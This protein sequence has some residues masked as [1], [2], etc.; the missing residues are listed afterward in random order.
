[1]DSKLYEELCRQFVARE[2]GVPLESVTSPKIPNPQRPDMP[3]YAH[4][5]DLYWEV[6]N[7]VALYLHIA[8]A[9]WRGSDNVK[10]GEVLLLQKVREKVAAH[11]AL[12]ITSHGFDPG[13]IAAAMDDGIGLHVVRPSFD[14]ASFPTRDRVAMQTAL[15]Q[16]S[17]DLYTHAIVNRGL[18]VGERPAPVAPSSRPVQAHTTR[19][20]TGYTTR[21]GPA[22]GSANRSLGGGGGPG[23][24]GI[25]TRDGGGGFTRGG[26]G[27]FDRR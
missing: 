22:P 19:E 17:G 3:K 27:G 4:Q 9:K 26:G 23:G 2:F 1:M 15:A 16:V 12:M 20:L 11:K 6:S 8:N 25:I 24:G 5:I 13:A 14:Y 18:D 7:K 10:E 21:E